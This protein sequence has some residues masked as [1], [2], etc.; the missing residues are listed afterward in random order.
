MPRE[1][2]Q[3]CSQAVFEAWLKPRIEAEPSIKS[4]FG[5]KF[6]SLTEHKD[7]VTSTFV[8]TSGH[9]HLVKSKYVIACDGAGSH[10]RQSVGIDLV[11]GPVYGLRVLM[12][13]QVY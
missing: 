12:E 10:V 13:T 1:P 3:R 11:G 4:L 7:F 8:D 9:K 2:Y 5:L 6:E